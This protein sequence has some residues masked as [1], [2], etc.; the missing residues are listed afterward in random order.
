MN[1]YDDY[2]NELV[3]Q[4]A[5]DLFRDFGIATE[6]INPG[7]LLDVMLMLEDNLKVDVD[8]SEFFAKNGELS[9]DFVTSCGPTSDDDSTEKHDLFDQFAE[10]QNVEVTSRGKHFQKGNFDYLIVFFYNQ[11]LDAN[12][13]NRYKK[14]NSQEEILPDH[15]LIIKSE[16]LAKHILENDE[17]YFDRIKIKDIKENQLIIKDE[18]VLINVPIEKLRNETNCLFYDKLDVDKEEVLDYLG[19]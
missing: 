19:L 4:M 8:K 3:E 16:D 11:F 17:Y 6:K 12:K 13:Y 10:K 5:Y 1:I 2:K 14:P 18:A 7:H 9:V 15:T